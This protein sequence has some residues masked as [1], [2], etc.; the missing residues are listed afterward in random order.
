MYTATPSTKPGNF[1]KL[2]YV[3][4]LLII[5]PSPFPPGSERDAA[6]TSTKDFH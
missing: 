1:A 2:V 4:A 3:A 5:R 6:R